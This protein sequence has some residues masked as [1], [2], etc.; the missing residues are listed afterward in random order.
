[1][2]RA[3]RW[4]HRAQVSRVGGPVG[5]V[6]ETGWAAGGGPVSTRTATVTPGWAFSPWSVERLLRASWPVRR[7]PSGA[8]SVRLEVTRSGD[9]V[10][11]ED[12][13]AAS[14]AV[15]GRAAEAVGDSHLVS[16]L[17]GVAVCLTP[18]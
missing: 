13:G 5:G 2:G 17:P 3:V 11:G 1:M 10:H 14:P 4:V 6:L 15:L 7:A 18:A 16:Y 8:G 9:V 12:Y